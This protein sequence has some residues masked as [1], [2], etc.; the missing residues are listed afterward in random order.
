MEWQWAIIAFGVFQWRKINHTISLVG[1]KLLFWLES[2]GNTY[3]LVQQIIEGETVELLFAVCLKPEGV[4]NIWW[5]EYIVGWLYKVIK[6][7]DNKSD[8][9]AFSEVI[10]CG[11]R[12]SKQ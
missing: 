1:D 2:N 6:T 3:E 5:L 12:R 10:T 11:E 4:K 9:E 7:I 8:R